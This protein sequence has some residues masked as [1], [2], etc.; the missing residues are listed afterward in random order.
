MGVIWKAG[1]MPNAH[2]AWMSI[3]ET[4]SKTGRR[5]DP[6]HEDATAVWLRTIAVVTV[7]ACALTSALTYAFVK[8]AGG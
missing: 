2:L 5:Y 8:M 1:T 4:T 7:F 3:V 6:D